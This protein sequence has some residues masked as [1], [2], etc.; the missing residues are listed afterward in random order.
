MRCRL[1][2][3]FSTVTP[4]PH[5]GGAFNHLPTQ[6]WS[7]ARQSSLQTSI[8]N[9][10]D[11]ALHCKH[12]VGGSNKTSCQTFLTL[13]DIMPQLYSIVLEEV[14]LQTFHLNLFL[15]QEAFLE[16]IICYRVIPL[17]H[18]RL[19][20]RI[21][22]L[23]RLLLERLL[24]EKLSLRRLSPRRRLLGRLSLRKLSIKRLSS[25]RLLLRK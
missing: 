17:S 20:F 1:Q 3:T 24:L 5:L 16:R 7:R 4:G 8:P 23:G 21:P 13:K 2:P 11:R 22:S 19:S 25:G 9:I 12:L 15:P 14:V 10:Q 6:Q 18:T